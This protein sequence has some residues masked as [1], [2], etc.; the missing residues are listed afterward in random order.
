MATSHAA[1]SPGAARGHEQHTTTFAHSAIFTVFFFDDSPKQKML[2]RID[3]AS[4][5][6]G[7]PPRW[8]PKGYTWSAPRF[9]W[10]THAAFRAHRTRPDEIVLFSKDDGPRPEGR[11]LRFN[12]PFLHTTRGAFFRASTS[13]TRA[14]PRTRAALAPSGLCRCPSTHTQ[15]SAR[16]AR[17]DPSPNG[18]RS[19]FRTRMRREAA[20]R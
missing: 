12:V 19:R 14:R 6:D 13:K 20:R 15:R 5:L 7:I 18:R 9:T 3:I 1:Q 17:A 16:A 10:V 2:V 8:N 4:E 11:V